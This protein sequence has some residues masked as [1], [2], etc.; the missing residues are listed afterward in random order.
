MTDTISNYCNSIIPA[1]ANNNIWG[2]PEG[3]ASIIIP[4]GI[5][6]FVFI[7]GQI[8]VWYRGQKTI[9]NETRNY[10]DIILSWIDFLE[11]SIEKNTKYLKDFSDRVANT[12]DV[13]PER[14]ELIEMLTD[15]IDSIGVDRFIRTFMINSTLSMEH[16][17]NGKMT[18]NLIAQFAFLTSIESHIKRDYESYQSRIFMLK[19][20]WNVAFLKLN[21]IVSDWG[22]KTAN[23]AHTLHDFHSQVHSIVQSW[24][25]AAVNSENTMIFSMTNLIT[26]LAQLAKNALE[27]NANNEYAY[28]LHKIVEKFGLV[29]VKWN[30][31]KKSD[32]KYYSAIA[33]SIEESYKSLVNAKDY[34][35]QK[36]KAKGIFALNK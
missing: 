4:A 9:Q 31:S 30:V 13:H 2:M 8:I 20:E 19:D 23:P 24:Q 27:Q 15:K 21:E 14:L 10:R 29:G 22:I 28:E 33:T 26:P 11:P 36:T 35:R 6:L 32:E 17:T 34:F 25:Q 1:E 12:K 5:T 16:S 3:F 18:Y 7:I